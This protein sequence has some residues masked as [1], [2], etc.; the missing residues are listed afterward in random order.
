VKWGSHNFDKMQEDRAASRAGKN[1][2][3]GKARA[4]TEQRRAK[5][6]ARAAERNRFS[7]LDIA[8][9]TDA[10]ERLHLHRLDREGLPAVTPNRP[11]LA[12]LDAFAAA[13]K[14]RSSSTILLQWPHGQRDIAICHALAIWPLLANS[15]VEVE[16]GANGQAIQWCPSIADFRTLYFPWRGGANASDQRLWLVDR[17]HLLSINKPHLTR[18]HLKK[19][20]QSP[21]LG[22][23]HE[24]LGHMTML[25]RR[26]ATHPHL[27]HPSLAELYPV[28]IA[29]GMAAPFAAAEYELFNRV[30]HGAAINEFPDH[31]PV[32]SDALAAPF[33]LFGI[34]ARANIRA[35][36]AAPAFE[37]ERGGR[38]PDICLL[39]LCAPAL[40]RLGYR[41]D[42]HVGRFL[43]E[44]F[45]AFPDIPLLAVTHDAYVQRRTD[46]LIRRSKA[47]RNASRR[48]ASRPVILR[49]SMVIGD[50]D[51]PVTA[52]SPVKATFQAIG[53]PSVDAIEAISAA[54]K[55]AS[56][57]AAAGALRR[58]AANV[59]RAA[60]L[61]CGLDDAY[62][63]L[64][65]IDGPAAA[66]VLLED[67]AESSVLLPI[68][69]A[70]ETGVGGAE[71]A[72]LDA[73]EAA[74][75]KAYEGL[76]KETPI[77]SSLVTLALRLSRAGS[78]GI[79]T[80]ANE[81]DLR[82]A[83]ARFAG[84][85]EAGAVLRARLTSGHTRI[86]HMGALEEVLRDVE[87]REDRNS[88]KRLILVAPPLAFL[89]RLMVRTWLPEDMLILCDRAFAKR[90]A[91]SYAALAA[92][93]DM[94]ASGVGSRLAAIAKD[95][96][97]E[98]EARAVGTI[99]LEF[100]ARPPVDVADEVVDITD[101]ETPSA[102]LFHVALE[103]GRTL[104]GRPG[105]AVVSYRH[106]SEV[107][108]FDRVLLRGL[109]PG[110]TIVVPDRAF[111]DAARR[112][113]PVHV[114]ARE[115]VGVYH[116]LIVAALPS[117][118]GATL[119]AKAKLLFAA[120][121]ARGLTVTSTATVHEWL[122]AEEHRAEPA[123]RMRPHAPQQRADFDLF[124]EAV[125]APEIWRSK[126]W[127]EG[128]DQ[129]RVDRRRAGFR[130]TKA[131]ISALV[132]PHAAAGLSRDVQDAIAALGT[133]ALE[134]LDRVRSAPAAG[135]VA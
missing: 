72:R 34:T 89:D 8:A 55:G 110:D 126:M 134:H 112:V 114:L 5:E 10:A 20:E 17:E 48:A 105:S 51:P 131:F 56:D 26:E 60:A 24:M 46:H 71:R 68:R 3:V 12:L 28:F 80:F 38:M 91:G 120:L 111:V 96:K 109:S 23:L 52:V 35:A 106:N 25:R 92:L 45:A 75:R 115:W 41:W 67:R 29:D 132:D 98:A 99:D 81:T 108:P 32:L 22:A 6:A 11:T 57:A 129:L 61:P 86:T 84:D 70:L 97:R 87:A 73:A 125:G 4:L 82:L 123:E 128:I 121:T 130:M 58:S 18:R 30:R 37:R 83:T 42:E 39:D 124:M 33:G 93:P 102:D 118:P 69:R 122:R 15:A 90:A 53:G 94:G 135:P 133:R 50:D 21:A 66:E 14:N 16:S 62:R 88:W 104:I 63:L 78:F 64:S 59:R 44:L 100:E 27:A 9:F 95:A 13:L 2:L 119:A 103:S 65:D 101:G 40:N 85:G 31:R 47:A 79:V 7:D 77:G 116:N 54:A 113:L 43:E 107:N 1:A 49:H 117:L 19:A 74:T 76:A 127:R 36:L